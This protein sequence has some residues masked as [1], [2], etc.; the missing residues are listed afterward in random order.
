VKITVH[1]DDGEIVF[2]SGCQPAVAPDESERQEV[3]QALMEA[4]IDLSVGRL[5][6]MPTDLFVEIIR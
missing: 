6:P 5:P 1:D 2:E 3:A 4:A